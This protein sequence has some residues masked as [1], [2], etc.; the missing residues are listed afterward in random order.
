[1]ILLI[2]PTFLFVVPAHAS[3]VSITIENEQVQASFSLS[4]EQNM[5][6]LPSQSDTLNIA[7]NDQLS[8]AFQS[9]FTNADPGSVPR[10]LTLKINSVGNWLNVSTTMTVSGVSV[11]NGD[12]LSANMTWKDLYIPSDLRSGNLSYNTIGSRYFRPVATFYSNA[13]K[14]VSRPNATITGVNFFV[15][16]TSVSGTAA[17]S[18]LGNFT[19]F[20]FR[21]LNSSLTH[22][23]RTYTLLNNT[24]RWRYAP[25]EPLDISLEVQRFNR[26][27]TMFARYGYE[28]EITVK[29]IARAQGNVLLFDVGTGQKEWVMVGVLALSAAM[30]VGMQLTFRQKRKKS[31][32]LGRW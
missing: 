22:W 16:K 1:M 13:S 25:P 2:I 19:L 18:Y 7:S 10:D 23:T 11:R 30:A 29:G 32:K 24:T 6:E 8:S 28:A 26:T 27:T 21:S 15:N 20:D 12:V 17:E 3:D 4:L 5:T 14:Y 31:I 9:A